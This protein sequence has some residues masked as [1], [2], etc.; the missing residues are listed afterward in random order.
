MLPFMCVVCSV[1]SYSLWPHGLQ[2]TRLLCPWDFSGKNTRVGCHFLLQGILPNSGIKPVSPM[3]PV[4]ADRFFTT[5][6]PGKPI[7]STIFFG[8]HGPTPIKCGRET[9]KV[10][11]GIAG[12][13][14]GW[15]LPQLFTKVWFV[16][17]ANDFFLSQWQWGFSH[18]SIS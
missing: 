16:F 4:L 10:Q 11:G 5:A 18:S 2:L 8:T 17:L 6:P 7:V 15:C 14:F 12:G 13:H 1:A 9:Y 3:S